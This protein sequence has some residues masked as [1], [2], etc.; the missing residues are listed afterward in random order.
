MALWNNTSS[1]EAH[2][3]KPRTKEQ[4]TKD[5]FNWIDQETEV[6]KVWEEFRISKWKR[7]IFWKHTKEANSHIDYYWYLQN[8]DQRFEYEQENEVIE[9]AEIRT[10]K[11][12]FSELNEIILPIDKL[13][14]LMK[15]WRLFK[16]QKY[17][18]HI[19]WKLQDWYYFLN[20]DYYL[21]HNFQLTKK[22]DYLI[23]PTRN[24]QLIK[25][26]WN[27]RR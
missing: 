23:I 1:A 10:L 7:P 16:C 17:N 11:K 21:R 18:V 14:D 2:F 20:W 9:I 6:I 4:R 19:I 12:K 25:K 3:N 22:H 13:N 24:L 15:F 8:P 26:I 5:Y 27:R